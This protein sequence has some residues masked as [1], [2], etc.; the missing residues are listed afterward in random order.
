MYQSN[1]YLFDRF[2]QSSFTFICEAYSKVHKE[3]SMRLGHPFYKQLV[4]Y[5]NIG[6][7]EVHINKG[8]ANRDGRCAEGNTYFQYSILTL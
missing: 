6:D 4:D 2:H 8:P 5:P 3:H 1:S 7:S